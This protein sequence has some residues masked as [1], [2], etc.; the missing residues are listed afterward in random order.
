MCFVLQIG[1]NTNIEWLI[2][3]LNS[4]QGKLRPHGIILIVENW[5]SFCYN[6]KTLKLYKT[7]MQPLA[8]CTNTGLFRAQHKRPTVALPGNICQFSKWFVSCGFNN[9]LYFSLLI[10]QKNHFSLS[11]PARHYSL[12]SKPEHFSPNTNC[13][14]VQG[15]IF[16]TGHKKCTRSHSWLEVAFNVQVLLSDFNSIYNLFIFTKWGSLP[17]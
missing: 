1:V 12:K 17:S 8:V 9:A 2:I 14:C 6:H 7:L 11:Y 16:S 4:A 3:L 5:F 10:F 13:I 15:R